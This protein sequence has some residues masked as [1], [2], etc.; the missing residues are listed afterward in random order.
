[1]K[2]IYLNNFNNKALIIDEGAKTYTL[3]SVKTAQAIKGA[4]YRVKMAR[5]CEVLKQLKTRDFKGLKRA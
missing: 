1:M 3:T 2:K 5:L 4:Y